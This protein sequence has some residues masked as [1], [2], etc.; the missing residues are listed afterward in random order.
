MILCYVAG[1]N[2]GAG[3]IISNAFSVCLSEIYGG[4]APEK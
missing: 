4:M 3:E 1:K 2:R